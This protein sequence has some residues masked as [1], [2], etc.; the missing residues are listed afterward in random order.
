MLTDINIR[1]ASKQDYSTLQR[2]ISFEFY[3][4]R[5][6]DWNSPLDWMEYSPFLLM[7]KDEKI[8]GALGCPE[9]PPGV[10]WIHL[11][12]S[13]SNYHPSLTLPH[14]LASVCDILNSTSD[15]VLI[16]AIS[17]Q[18]WFTT[19]LTNNNFQHF[20]DIVVLEKE[21]G[22]REK[23]HQLPK[24]LLIRSMEPADLIRVEDID[25]QS[26]HPL[27]HNSLNILEEA[28]KQSAY[29]TVAIFSGEL[30][31][32]QISTVTSYNAHLARLA[33]LPEF[34]KLGIG[35]GLITDLEYHFQQK[36]LTRL[37][38]N[39]QSDNLSSLA[40]YRKCGFFQT[41]EAYPVLVFS[42]S[43]AF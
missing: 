3:V 19:L 24:N 22:I 15:Q 28:W 31:G 34:Q 2:L 39:T 33:V 32:Y 7:E 6:L 36:G 9:G 21:I 16:S 30:V 29:G 4:H 17:L 43:P 5:H 37:T 10:N 14:L 23:S 25:R 40:I 11:F 8:I 1:S 27:W 12:F 38:V 26:F 35:T 41:G 42:Y 13:A 18:S 20:Q